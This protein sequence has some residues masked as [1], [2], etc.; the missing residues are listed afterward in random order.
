MVPVFVC[1]SRGEAIRYDFLDYCIGI[2]ECTYL[3]TL[4]NNRAVIYDRNT[5]DA[6]D[7]NRY[8]SLP[9]LFDKRYGNNVIGVVNIHSKTILDNYLNTYN[10]S[11]KAYIVSTKDYL[12]ENIN[13]FHRIIIVYCSKLDGISGD[14]IILDNKIWQYKKDPLFIDSN[15]I[16]YTAINK[17]KI[18]VTASSMMKR[19][20][21]PKEKEILINALVS[22]E[23]EVP[24][25][26]GLPLLDI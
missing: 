1:N 21:L 9:I 19:L 24:Y 15:T 18:A 12:I 14:S 16:V 13:T 5:V 23:S 11:N 22:D 8:N 3:D 6:I 17:I 20:L 10:L 4:F 2:N 26:N 7:Y 25:V